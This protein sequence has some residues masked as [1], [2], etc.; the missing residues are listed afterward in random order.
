VSAQAI[1]KRIHRLRTERG[2]TQRQLAIPEERIS[3]AYISRVE[4]G[5]RNP[6]HRALRV[7]ATKLETTALFLETGR[8]DA[9]CPHCHRTGS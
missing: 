8:L 2:L 3:Y 5:L 1:G 7:L 4:R 9:P 6:S